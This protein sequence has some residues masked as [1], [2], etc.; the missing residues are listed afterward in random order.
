MISTVVLRNPAC[1]PVPWLKKSLSGYLGQKRSKWMFP[2]VAAE[3]GYSGCLE[4]QRVD[5]HAWWKHQLFLASTCLMWEVLYFWT[6]LRAS[7]YSCRH[8][9]EQEARR[10]LNFE[11]YKGSLLKIPWL[12]KEALCQGG[13]MRNAV[14]ARECIT[15]KIMILICSTEQPQ[16]VP[17]V[18]FMKRADPQWNLT[19]NLPAINISST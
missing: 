16:Y 19:T 7:E 17:S 5:S 9:W 1:P 3:C 6:P 13:V 2:C 4:D 18:T 11:N 10:F 15:S 14:V 12:V 8:G